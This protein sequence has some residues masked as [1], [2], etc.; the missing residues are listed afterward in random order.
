MGTCVNLPN[1]IHLLSYNIK[2]LNRK[3]GAHKLLNFYRG[4]NPKV[5]IICFQ[6]HKLCKDRPKKHSKNLLAK[7]STMDD[8]SE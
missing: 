2:R 6:E 8:K 1:S 7:N 4:L 3:C 5:D